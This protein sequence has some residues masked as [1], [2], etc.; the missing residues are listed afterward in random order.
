MAGGEPPRAAQGFRAWAR[1]RRPPFVVLGL[2]LV[3]AG[4]DLLLNPPKG[5]LIELFS[6]PLLAAGG[7]ILATVLWPEEAGAPAPPRATLASRL[8]HRLPLP[9]RLLPPPPPPR[10]P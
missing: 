3:V 5:A 4:V 1:E 6:I 7:L 10:L 8:V 9:G 2:I